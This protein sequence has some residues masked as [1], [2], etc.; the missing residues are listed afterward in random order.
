MPICAA[1]AWLPLAAYVP[2]EVYTVLLGS[3]ALEHVLVAM[4]D[5]PNL[6][7]LPGGKASDESAHLIASMVMKPV[8]ESLRAQFDF[9]VLDSSPII[10]YAEGRACP[11]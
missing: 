5:S 9:I 7:I 4:E 6:V 1:H 2:I 3:V 8:M 10:P 11:L